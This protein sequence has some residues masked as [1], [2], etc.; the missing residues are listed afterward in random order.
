[1][2][3]FDGHYGKLVEDWGLDEWT[4][5]YH[6]HFET[7]YFESTLHYLGSNITEEF[8]LPEYEMAALVERLFCGPYFTADEVAEAAYLHFVDFI[9]KYEAPLS[10][11]FAVDT[12]FVK[13]GDSLS[14]HTATAVQRKLFDDVK[15]VRDLEIERLLAEPIGEVT[16]GSVH[17]EEAASRSIGLTIRGETKCYCGGS[18]HDALMARKYAY[19][20]A[21]YPNLRDEHG[22]HWAAHPAF[23]R[24]YPQ[25]VDYFANLNDVE[26]ARLD[27]CKRIYD[28]D[29]LRYMLVSHDRWSHPLSNINECDT[30]DGCWLENSLEAA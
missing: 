6:D 5:F 13:A 27:K 2:K 19:I 20:V 17:T 3:R 9:D 7:P 26:R 15:A 22:D 4:R 1:M 23:A 12:Q 28:L 18:I 16:E 29:L 30:L 8:V 11:Y 21:K 24:F 10:R 25:Y 14:F